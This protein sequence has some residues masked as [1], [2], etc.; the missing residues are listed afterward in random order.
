MDKVIVKLYSC[1]ECGMTMW[2]ES[3]ADEQTT[4]QMMNQ[5]P[6]CN[7]CA[8]GKVSFSIERHTGRQANAFDKPPKKYKGFTYFGTPM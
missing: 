6:Y 4:L 1:K 7:K 8:Q 2:L 3:F 5:N